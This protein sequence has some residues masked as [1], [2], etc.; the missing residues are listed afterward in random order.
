MVGVLA[1]YIG[2]VLNEQLL[3]WHPYDVELKKKKRSEGRYKKVTVFL[4]CLFYNKN[5][6]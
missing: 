4:F 3:R 1:V 5:S 2:G 6:S